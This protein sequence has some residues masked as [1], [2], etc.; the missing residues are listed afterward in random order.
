MTKEEAELIIKEQN[1]STKEILKMIEHQKC[2]LLG[3]IQDKDKAIKDLEWQLR[4]VAKDNDYYQ[5][6]NKR[7]EKQIEKM[8]CCENCGNFDKL[9]NRCKLTRFTL[10]SCLCKDMDKWEIKEN[11]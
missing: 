9:Y 11:D 5:A 4:E 7:L 1:K 6:E 10:K 3:I 2:E 8:K